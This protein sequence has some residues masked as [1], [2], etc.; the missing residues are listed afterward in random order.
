VADLLISRVAP[1]VALIRSVD[2]FDTFE[3]YRIERSRGQ[4]VPE[5]AG[6]YLLH[7]VTG[8]GKL[9]VYLGM[10]TSN[11]R[12]RIRSHH[13]NP[14]KNW[15]GVLFAVPVTSPMLCPAI[16][17]ELI[18]ELTEADVVDVI[19]NV[20]EERRLRGADDVHIEPAVEKIREGLQLLLGSDIFTPHD[21][22]EGGSIDPPLQRL[23]PLER[24][25]KGSAS[26][27]RARTEA[28]PD[29]ATH[30][31]VGAGVTA[32]G[33]FEGDEPDKRFHVLGGSSW[34]QATIDPEMATYDA[35]RRVAEAQAKL[36][37]DGALDESGMTFSRDHLFDNW[38]VAS[39][40]V[41]GK[42]TYSGAYHWQR[43]TG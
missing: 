34:R 37:H 26:E 20:S 32:W 19:A 27:A 30:S 7:G 12:N 35:Q 25:Y 8:E 33:R 6:I 43:L 16:E 40:I 9:T 22:V 5:S 18:G 14:G 17:A 10:S 23:P 41:S 39:R 15:F 4:S 36:I 1:G 24:A 38:S 31:Y 11:M 2:P 29:D 28:D 42:G 13:V 3:I 21:A